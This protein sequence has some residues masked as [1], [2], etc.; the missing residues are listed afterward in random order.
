MIDWEMTLTFAIFSIFGA[1]TRA[2]LGIY[3]GY[4]TIPMFKVDWKR[5]AVEITAS[6]FFGTFGVYLLS[7]IDALKFGLDAISLVAG[8]LGA[9]LMSLITKRVGLTK[10]L[11]IVV[12]EQQLALAE[13]NDR[14]IA[15][16]EFLREHDRITNKMYQKLNDVSANIAQKDLA[17]LVK[18]RKLKKFGRGKAIYYKLA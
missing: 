18:K 16:L 8:F 15:A 13:F 5:V 7:K 10:G 17:H 14:Q 3:K 2:M 6:V 1:I 11:Q 12:S 4:T 9:D